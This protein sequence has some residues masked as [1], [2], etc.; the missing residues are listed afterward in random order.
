V[1]AI[2]ARDSFFRAVAQIT[3]EREAARPIVDDLRSSFPALW[4][5]ELPLSWRTAGF[6]QELTSAAVVTL[7]DDPHRSLELAQFALA[8]ATSIPPDTY[9]P[10]VQAQLEGAA[11]KEIGTAHRYLS[12]YDAALRAYDAAQRCFAGSSTLAHDHAVVDFARAIVLTDLGQHDDAR[13]LIGEVMPVLRGFGDRRR[14]VQAVMMTGII[15]W[16]QTRLTEA[17]AAFDQALRDVGS[18]D[19]HTKAALYNNLGY[20][21]TDLGDFN[22]AVLMLHHAR[23]LFMELGMTGEVARTE[24]ALARVLLRTA[25]FPRAIPILQRTRESFVERGMIEEAGLA[26]LNLVEAL[27]AT[28]KRD[29]ARAVTERVLSEFRS[30]GLN[31][32]AITAL[33]YLRDILPAAGQPERAVHHVRTYLEQLRT[34]PSRA[35]LPLPDER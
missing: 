19:L 18:D 10:P 30:A 27:L 22:E 35:F 15:H 25:E 16:R 24:W 34:E 2:E 17:R 11:W 8:V 1:K 5:S 28:D 9:P 33:A 29:E 13:R 21:C 23:A 26:G 32:R 12:E 3:A 20:L 7:E 6:V 31:A 4:E 14:L